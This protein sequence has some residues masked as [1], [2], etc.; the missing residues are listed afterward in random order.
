DAGQFQLAPVH[1]E[2]VAAACVGALN[3][4]DANGKIF[5]LCGAQAVSWKQIIQT[6]AR[7]SGRSGKFA[8]PA[9]AELL[10]WVASVL[11]KQLWFPITRDQLTMLLEGNT[12]NERSAW[13]FFRIQPKAFALENLLYLQR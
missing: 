6:L 8:L 3:N 4:P 1:V 2:D 5:H 12:C 13:E 11:D 10:K 7:A 9:P